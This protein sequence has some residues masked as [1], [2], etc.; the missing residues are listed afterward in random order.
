MTVDDLFSTLRGIAKRGTALDSDMPS[1]FR[2]ALGFVEQNYN[3][4]WLLTKRE[5]TVAAGATTL[6]IADSATSR[7][8]NLESVGYQDED[9]GW[10][11]LRRVDPGDFRSSEGPPAGYVLTRG[12]DAWLLTFDAAWAEETELTLYTYDLT[13]WSGNT[14]D[15]LHTVQELED[16]ITARCMI[17]L[18]PIMR[19]P[20]LLQ[21]YNMQWLEAITVAIN[22]DGARTQGGR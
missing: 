8:K 20:A 9:G 13:I 4:S 11:Y 10:H 6:E 19:D 3:W 1:A 14:S 22:T 18:A 17:Y 7:M 12:S 15:E 2:K 21:M 16:A 5:L